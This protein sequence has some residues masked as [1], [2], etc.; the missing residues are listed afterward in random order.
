MTDTLMTDALMTDALLLF[1]P[2]NLMGDGF[3]LLQPQPASGGNIL[4]AQSM[5]SQPLLAMDQPVG[6]QEKVS[7]MVHVEFEVN[8][9]VL[10]S[11]FR[12]QKRRCVL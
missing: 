3:G 12:C 4:Q 5:S 9:T 1:S 11:V 2:Q 7:S 10:R 6:Q 8:G